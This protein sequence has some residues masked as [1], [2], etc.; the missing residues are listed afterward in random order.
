MRADAVTN[1]LSRDMQ[2]LVHQVGLRK[3]VTV[4]LI[5]IYDVL[6]IGNKAIIRDELLVA[7][8][9]GN[10]HTENVLKSQLMFEIYD[11]RRVVT[12][13]CNEAAQVTNCKANLIC[14]VL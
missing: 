9:S 2:K 10:K 7:Y 3:S 4:F 12:N 5:R 8:L 13:H 14:D 6:E 11:R 1:T